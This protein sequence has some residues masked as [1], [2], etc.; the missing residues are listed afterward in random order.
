MVNT[1]FLYNKD[2]YRDRKK[3]LRYLINKFHI[4]N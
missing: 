2:V 3:I 1:D 4:R